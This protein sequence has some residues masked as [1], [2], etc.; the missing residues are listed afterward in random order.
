MLADL[1]LLDLLTQTGTISGT[2]LANNPDLFGALR[3]QQSKHTIAAVYRQITSQLKGAQ[4]LMMV[5]ACD[6]PTR[7]MRTHIWSVSRL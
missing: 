2:V 3:L 4:Q 7:Q 6:L 1:C 5:V